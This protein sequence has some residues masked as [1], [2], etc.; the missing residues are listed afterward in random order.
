M[1]PR[2]ALVVDDVVPRAGWGS[3]YPRSVQIVRALS[4]CSDEVKVCPMQ[5]LLLPPAAPEAFG[6]NVQPIAG[7]GV[8][9]L[10]ATPEANDGQLG[11]LWVSRPRNLA[12]VYRLHWARAALFSG[13][14]I[15]Y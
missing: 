6:D 11:L 15:A 3:G 7:H 1:P 4:R 8:A 14:R 10:H 12:E 2:R 13:L 9:A 5:E